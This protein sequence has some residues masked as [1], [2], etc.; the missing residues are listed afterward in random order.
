MC[1]FVPDM[2]LTSHGLGCQFQVWDSLRFLYTEINFRGRHSAPEGIP[3]AAARK[4]AGL[5][6]GFFAAAYNQ[7]FRL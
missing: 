6:L 5:G 7:L 1:E 2:I 4:D 3:T